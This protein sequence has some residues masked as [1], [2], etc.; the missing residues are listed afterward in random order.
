MHA[1]A[2]EEQSLFLDSFLIQKTNQNLTREHRLQGADEFRNVMRSSAIKRTPLFVFRSKSNRK[3]TARIGFSVPSRLVKAAT[4]R[5]RIKRV[6]RESFR[7]ERAQLPM[8]DYVVIYV[9]SSEPNGEEAR[10]VLN[11]FWGAETNREK[12]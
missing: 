10:N 5:N 12:V 9:G 6:I 8:R 3:G 2:R 4:E 11:A 7:R 1:V